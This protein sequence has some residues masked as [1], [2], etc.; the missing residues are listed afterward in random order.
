M[1]RRGFPDANSEDVKDIVS[2][3][4]QVG[5][6]K[7]FLRTAAFEALEKLR[8]STMNGA[9]I[10]LQARTRAFL[11]APRR[12]VCLTQRWRTLCRTW[13]ALRFLP[14]PIALL[15]SRTIWWIRRSSI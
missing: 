13:S 4:L 14:Y 8:G 10:T 3:G 5:R 9:V 15:T 6:L 7:V 1:R 2:W 12:Q 11:W